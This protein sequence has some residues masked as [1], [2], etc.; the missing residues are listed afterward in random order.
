MW[1][2]TRCLQVCTFCLTHHKYKVPAI[3][4]LTGTEL[5]GELLLVHEHSDHY[6]LQAATVMT[7]EGMRYAVIYVTFMPGPGF[8]IHL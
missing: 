4:S 8:T 3:N 5:P 7:V 1:S 6:S 2:S